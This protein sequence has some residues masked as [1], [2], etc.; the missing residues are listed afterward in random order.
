MLPLSCRMH[1]GCSH[2]PGWRFIIGVLQAVGMAAFS[3]IAL[4]VCIVLM[5][6]V[7][8]ATASINGGKEEI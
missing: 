3:W 4:P 5:V 7:L 8:P 6:G 1:Y 2:L